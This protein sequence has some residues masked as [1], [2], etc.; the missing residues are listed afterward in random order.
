MSKVHACIIS[1]HDS[2]FNQ[3]KKHFES[4]DYIESLKPICDN[5]TNDQNNIDILSHCSL[6][7]IPPNYLQLSNDLVQHIKTLID[8]NR[9]ACI[10]FRGI[11]TTAP[12]TTRL[13]YLNDGYVDYGQGSS[14]QVDYKILL[15][16]ID[17]TN[18]F[19]LKS[20][21]NYGKKMKEFYEN[22]KTKDIT[23]IPGELQLNTQFCTGLKPQKLCQPDDWI[24]FANAYQNSELRYSI[25]LHKEKKVLF[26]HWYAFED[27]I[28][29]FCLDLLQSFVQY[30]VF[31]HKIE[32]KLLKE[33]LR[34][35]IL[36]DFKLNDINIVLTK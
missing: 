2:F 3:I 25:L 10:F 9:L 15:Q 29:G 16:H 19:H 32:K 26:S 22:V 21:L 13:G 4:C 14:F 18:S 1:Y 5:L 27:C 20:L 6:L 12:L 8:T 33:K 31:E 24:C 35:R 7:L 30:L 17:I 11:T 28:E 36:E 34:V 23:D